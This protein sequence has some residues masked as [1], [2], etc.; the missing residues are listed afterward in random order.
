VNL[1]DG[2]KQW[3]AKLTEKLTELNVNKLTEKLTL[4]KVEQLKLNVGITA[5]IPCHLMATG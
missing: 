4:V 2:I 1:S 5:S 3:W